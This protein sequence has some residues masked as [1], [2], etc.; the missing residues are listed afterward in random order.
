MED[1]LYA[2][3]LQ[4]DPEQLLSLE[5]AA[6]DLLNDDSTFSSSLE[7]TSTV[8]V[9]GLL[10]S[11]QPHPTSG[12]GSSRSHTLTTDDDIEEAKKKAIPQNTD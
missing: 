12:A 8:P 2:I 10:P 1:E 7:L 6:F 4:I 11:S 9:Q 5:S 3:I